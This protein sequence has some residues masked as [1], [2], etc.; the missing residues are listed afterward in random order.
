MTPLR[1]TLG[2]LQRLA[3]ELL[4]QSG[5]FALFYLLIQ[6]SISGW[7]LFSDVG[8]TSLLGI[9]LLQTAVLVVWGDRPW[10]RLAGSLIAPLFYTFL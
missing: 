3:R 2:F 8:H 10:V 5:Q 4:L 7:G 1:S 9:L 6:F